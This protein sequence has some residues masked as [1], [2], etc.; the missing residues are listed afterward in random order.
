MAAS[1]L[2]KGTYAP[3]AAIEVRAVCRGGRVHVELLLKQADPEQVAA[4]S[5]SPLVKDPVSG[6]LMA[7]YEAGTGFEALGEK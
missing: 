5:G 6:Y 4:V 7:R 2:G 3:K 1:N